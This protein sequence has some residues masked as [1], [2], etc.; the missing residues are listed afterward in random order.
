MLTSNYLCYSPFEMK[1]SYQEA[2]S[3]ETSYS[4]LDFQA[5]DA[6]GCLPAGSHYQ[7]RPVIMG[8]KPFPLPAAFSREQWQ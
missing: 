5:L 6:P 8:I 3:D 7:Y 4:P 1:A 2:T